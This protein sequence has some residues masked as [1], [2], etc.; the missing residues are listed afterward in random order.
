MHQD[1]EEEIT[2]EYYV[3]DMTDELDGSNL[4]WWI[5]LGVSIVG[6]ALGAYLGG[7]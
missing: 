4:P 5:L 7:L 3:P 2:G 1:F 6:I